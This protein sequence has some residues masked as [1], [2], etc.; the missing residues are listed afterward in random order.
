MPPAVPQHC[1]PEHGADAKD[2]HPVSGDADGSARS[3]GADGA[4]GLLARVVAAKAREGDGLTVVERLLDSALA[5]AEHG[6][7]TTLAETR[8]ARDLPDQIYA[9]RRHHPFRLIYSLIV[10][11]VRHHCQWRSARRS[12]RGDAPAWADKDFSG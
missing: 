6:G 2:S 9:I 11:F 8:L 7:D 3:N 4:F 12:R 5:H 1:A 10:V